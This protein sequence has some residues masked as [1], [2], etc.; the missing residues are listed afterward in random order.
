MTTGATT[1]EWT[2]PDGRVWTKTVYASIT[3]SAAENRAMSRS[4]YE[5][6]VKGGLHG[7]S[8]NFL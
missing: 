7:S 3:I 8:R 5:K 4:P 1:F 6:L 2:D